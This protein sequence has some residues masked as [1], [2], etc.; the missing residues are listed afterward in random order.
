[1]R[2]ER[3]PHPWA[4]MHQ[5]AVASRAGHP[6]DGPIRTPSVVTGAGG[7]KQRWR[8]HSAEGNVYAADVSIRRPVTPET[9]REMVLVDEVALAPDGRTAFFTRR[10]IEGIDYRSEIWCVALEGDPA[11][12][13]RVTSGPSDGLPRVSPDGGWLAYLAKPRPIERTGAEP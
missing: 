1:M 9:V 10:W 5:S 2:R 13:R 3:H 6:P 7:R 4:Q 11:P 12:P 8:S